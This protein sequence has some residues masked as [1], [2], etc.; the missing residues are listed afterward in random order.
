MK[1]PHLF[2]ILFLALL[3]LHASAQEYRRTITVFVENKSPFPNRVQVRDVEARLG[4]P[5]DC[6]VAKKVAAQ[7]EGDP[8]R[9]LRPQPSETSMTCVVALALLDEPRCSIKDLVFDDWIDGGEKVR[10]TI[11]TGTDGYGLL[12]VRAVNNTESW[13]FKPGIRGGDTVGHQ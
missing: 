9:E 3:P 2:V 1:L 8:K 13:T 11:H 10:L 5:E 6:R 7:C 4:L 12:A